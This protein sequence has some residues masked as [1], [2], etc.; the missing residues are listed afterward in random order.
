MLKMNKNAKD[1]SNYAYFFSII[2]DCI[3]AFTPFSFI[4]TE[5]VG[6]MTQKKKMPPAPP[7]G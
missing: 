6:K 1:R 5:E 2:T 7:K 4:K 3:F